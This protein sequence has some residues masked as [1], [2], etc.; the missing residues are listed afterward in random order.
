LGICYENGEGAQQNLQRA[1]NYYRLSA[2]QGLANAQHNLG[3]CYANGQGVAKDNQR[4]IE[5]FQKAASQGFGQAKDALNALNDS[6]C[7]ISTAAA[8]TLGWSDDGFE[9]NALRHLRDTFMRAK[10]ERQA[11]VEEYYRVAPGIVAVISARPD[12][13]AIWHEIG[14]RWLG[15]I[16]KFAQSGKA[17]RAHELY[18][19]MVGELRAR[20]GA[21]TGSED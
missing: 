5:W 9:L 16:L 14:E 12:A 21:E 19:A 13:T 17:Q 7:F 3:C 10:P 2:E 18:C 6:S 1:V 4:A 8:Q 11:E 20:F 15:P